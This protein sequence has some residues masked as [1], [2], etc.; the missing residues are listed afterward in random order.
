MATS[1]SRTRKVPPFERKASPSGWISDINARE[2]KTGASMMA[3]PLGNFHPKKYQLHSKAK[4]GTI[5]SSSLLEVILACFPLAPFPL[6]KLSELEILHHTISKLCHTFHRTH[7]KHRTSPSILHSAA[8]FGPRSHSILEEDLYLLNAIRFK[9]RTKWVAVF[10][11][12]IIDVGNNN[13]CNLPYGVFISKIL[14]LSKIAF[15]GETKI[16]CSR[17]NQIGKVTLTCIGLKKTVLGWIFSDVQN[18]T[19]DQD[20]L[21]DSDSEQI[22][23]SPKSEFEK[24]VVNKFEKVSKSASMMKKSLMRMNEKMDEII[25]NYAESAT[26]T[27]KSTDEVEESSKTD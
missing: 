23:L 25:K 7:S 3:T 1:S 2:R 10:K 5:L 6:G 4:K 26:S 8:T 9:I 21:P 14:S 19:N 27:E 18:S 16:T 11:K 17:N 13:G 15:T 22:L 12:H 24:F 20:A